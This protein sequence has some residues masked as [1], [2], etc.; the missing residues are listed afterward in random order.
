MKAHRYLIDTNVALDLLLAREPFEYDAMHIFSLAEL[1]EIDLVLS[2]DAI[3]TIGY[4]ISK[5]KDKQAAR[6]AIALLLDFVSL[7]PLDESTVLKALSLDFSDI[8]DA[9]VASAADAA[10]ARAIITRNGA[11]FAKSSIPAISPKEFLSI[12]SQ[13]MKAKQQNS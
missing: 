5:N 7:A 2:S 3:S 6:Q 12:R 13:E 1:G 4:H 8:E 11:D 10:G 9:L